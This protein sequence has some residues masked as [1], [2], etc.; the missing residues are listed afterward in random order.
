M[1][2]HIQL[3]A[4]TIASVTLLA[5][6][7]TVAPTTQTTDPYSGEAKTSNT[8]KGAGIGAL[9]GAVLGAATSSKGDRKKGILTGALLGGAVGGGVGYYMDQQEAELRRYL[10][11]TGVQVER[12][13]DRIQL[14]MP[15]NIT[16][17]T[18]SSN[19]ATSFFSVLDG[20]SVVLKKYEQTQLNIDGHTDSVG[21]ESS[22]QQLSEQRA[23]S[24]SYYLSGQGISP[25]RMRTAGYGESSPIADNRNTEGRAANRRVELWIEPQV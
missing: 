8:V 1:K 13:G 25:Q 11:G 10:Q 16:F 3:T 17:E 19:L 24:V 5:G 20:V 2:R 6:C 18:G 9:A 15:G 4:A 12:H 14:V 7:Q 23:R 21:S 22:N